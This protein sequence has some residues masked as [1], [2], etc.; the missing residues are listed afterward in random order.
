MKP[1]GGVKGHGQEATKQQRQVEQSRTRHRGTRERRRP[2]LVAQE[3]LEKPLRG[4]GERDRGGHRGPLEQRIRISHPGGEERQE[5]LD[6]D[7]E[8]EGREEDVDRPPWLTQ[9][10][11]A[12]DRQADD[13]GYQCG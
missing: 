10:D 13:G 11:G 2:G 12:T 9:K 4:R 7:V 6:R 1:P 8:G 3:G 5:L